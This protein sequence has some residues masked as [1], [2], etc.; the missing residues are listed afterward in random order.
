[1]ES[2]FSI[3]II[4][5]AYKVLSPA[6][7]HKDVYMVTKDWLSKYMLNNRGPKIDP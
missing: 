1:M 5:R 3:E 7:L 4:S 2:N 6:M